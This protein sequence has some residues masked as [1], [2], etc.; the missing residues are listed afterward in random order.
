MAN[1]KKLCLRG[2]I[3]EVR[4]M[5]PADRVKVKLKVLIKSGSIYSQ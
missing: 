4:D 3:S 2:R 5:E 1:S